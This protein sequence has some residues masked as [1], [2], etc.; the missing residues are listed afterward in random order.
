MRKKIKKIVV[1]LSL[2]VGAYSNYAFAA[3]DI[4]VVDDEKV[5]LNTIAGKKLNQKFEKVVEAFQGKT[6]KVGISLEKERDEIEK[7]R[8]VIKE[9][10]FEKLRVDFEKKI[11]Q[12]R[13]EFQE[14]R[15]KIEN[16][17][18]EA[19]E[20]L[21]KV[22]REA[23]ASLAVDLSFKMVIPSSAPIY[24]EQSLDITDKVIKIVDSK[25][26]EVPFDIK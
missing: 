18:L 11:E 12:S 16:A 2:L 8:L 10:A 3:N 6:E 14:E 23:T 26:K 13:K 15:N 9:E 7:K 22:A 5:M 20:K 1:L 24:F 4:V 17:R 25:L 19:I 21:S